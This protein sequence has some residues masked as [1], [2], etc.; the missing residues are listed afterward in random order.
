MDPTTYTVS[1]L[2]QL[3]QDIKYNL[4]AEESK[5]KPIGFSELY[6]DTLKR[7]KLLIE[8]ELKKRGEDL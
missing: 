6:I 5:G 1:Q 2:R 8:G 4:L 3:R 7:N